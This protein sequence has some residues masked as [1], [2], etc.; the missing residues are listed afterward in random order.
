MLMKALRCRCPQDLYSLAAPVLKTLCKDEVTKRV[1]D[2]KPG[3][4]VK[5]IYDEIHGPDIKFYYGAVDNAFAPDAPALQRARKIFEEDNK[6]PRNLFYNKVDELEDEILFPEERLPQGMDP[7]HIGKIEPLRVWEEEGFSLR[8]FIEG[9]ES[10]Y[11]DE[12]FD[13]D[14]D[15]SEM[16]EEDVEDLED[17]DGDEDFEDIDEDHLEEQERD[18][19]IASFDKSERPPITSGDILQHMPF[20]DELK[21]VMKRLSLRDPSSRPMNRDILSK[22][23][24]E[25][26]MRDEFMAYLDKEKARIFKEVW[27]K[28]DLAPHAQTHYIEMME[29]TRKCRKFNHFTFDCA[30]VIL[31]LNLID[32]LDV[33]YEDK[34]D[35]HKTIAKLTPFFHKEFFDS[36]DGEAF[37]ES[38][39]FKQEEKSQSCCRYSVTPFC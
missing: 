22:K 24:N 11:S 14:E 27:H 5:S 34:K 36:K 16:D 19:Q 18:T 6:F 17:D 20:S 37:K 33:K 4:N 25:S 30:P 29:M 15:G 23:P 31:A 21:D 38:L 28:A 12:D 32:D 10:D 8:K 2:I 9:W 3:E 7:L 26:E 39:L 13:E 35:L 1:R